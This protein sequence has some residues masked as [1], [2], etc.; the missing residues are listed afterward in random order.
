M[1]ACLMLEDAI[2]PLRGDA[3]GRLGELTLANDPLL[4]GI[5]IQYLPAN[6]PID[7]LPCPNH[8]HDCEG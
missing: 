8:D 4:E 7:P 1:P 6:L 5:A 2:L 3:R